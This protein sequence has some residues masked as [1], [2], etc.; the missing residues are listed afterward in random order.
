ME[1]CALRVARRMRA[2]VRADGCGWVW[3]VYVLNV[4]ATP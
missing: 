2:Y 1:V 4:K 3:M